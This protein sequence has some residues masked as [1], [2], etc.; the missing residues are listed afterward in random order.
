MR[1]KFV[2]ARLGLEKQHFVVQRSIKDKK[3]VLN[4]LTRIRREMV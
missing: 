1:I 4:D 3:K 2:G